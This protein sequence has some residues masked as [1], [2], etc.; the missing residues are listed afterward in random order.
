MDFDD[1]LINIIED[2]EPDHQIE[3]SCHVEPWNLLVVD[4]DEGV[5]TVTQLALKNITIF[6]R[7]LELFHCYSVN[8]TKELLRKR[9]DFAVILLDVV[10][11]T[12]DAGLQMVGFIRKEM[13]M[14]ECRII[15]RTGQPGYAP[16]LTIF[17]DYD[18][19]DYR[20]KS[21]LTRTRLITS[22]TAAIRSYR[23]IHTISENRR[24]LELIIR[25]TSHLMDTKAISSFSQGVLTQLASLLDFPKNG[26]VCVQKGFPNTAN[27]NGLFISGAAGPLANLITH[28]LTDMEN[29][30]ITAAIEKAV[31]SKQHIYGEGF[32]VIYLQ[33][34]TNEGA[35]YINTIKHPSEDD[36]RLLEVFAANMSACFDNVHLVERL[37]YD[38]YNDPLTQ[39][40]NKARFALEVEKYTRGTSKEGVVAL[41]D[42]NHFSDLNE[43]LGIETADTFLVEFAKR[44]INELQSECFVARIRG[45]IFGILGPSE[46]VNPVRLSGVMEAPFELQ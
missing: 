12:D 10:M 5:H 6:D 2:D 17:N 44:L 9:N 37:N 19:N 25:A 4:D 41:I 22:I 29:P 15:L 18:I 31:E 36:Q 27:P 28:P 38:A 16:E 23:Q 20:T 39:L 3:S 24:G 21:E 42:I 7:P 43:G 34:N 11:E 35:V 14:D 46:D 26:V 8:E 40:P 32:C 30:E 45:D 13:C 1:E 33:S